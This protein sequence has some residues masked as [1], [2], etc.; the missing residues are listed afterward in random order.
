MPGKVVNNSYAPP[1]MCED[2]A[3]EQGILEA[4]NHPACAA[5]RA[6]R[7]AAKAFCAQAAMS[8]WPALGAGFNVVEVN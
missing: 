7:H 1:D 6:V 5:A 2:L 4:G 3:D 8:A